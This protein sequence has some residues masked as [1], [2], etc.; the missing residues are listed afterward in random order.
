MKP[1]THKTQVFR[2]HVLVHQCQTMY[3]AGFGAGF[4]PRK[5]KKKKHKRVLA[6]L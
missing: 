2:K 3:V 4:Y 5:K 1:L 6:D